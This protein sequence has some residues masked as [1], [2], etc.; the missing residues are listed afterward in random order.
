M[1][2]G[3]KETRP[4]VFQGALGGRSFNLRHFIMAETVNGEA[5]GKRRCAD[6]LRRLGSANACRGHILKRSR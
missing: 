2:A 4:G 1:R 6:G 3:D 5:G